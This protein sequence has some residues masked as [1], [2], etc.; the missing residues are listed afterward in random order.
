MKLASKRPFSSGDSLRS[1]DLWWLAVSGLQLIA[2]WS[3]CLS[4][5]LVWRLVAVLVVAMLFGPTNLAVGRYLIRKK[6]STADFLQSFTI[7]L[8]AVLVVSLGSCVFSGTVSAFLGLNYLGYFLAV[9]LLGLSVLAWH[10]AKRLL[11]A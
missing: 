4:S 5:S 3:C 7:T 11:F 9:G 2:A 8:I 1:C 10:A 6:P